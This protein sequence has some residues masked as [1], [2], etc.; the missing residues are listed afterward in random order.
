MRDIFRDINSP[1][2]TWKRAVL[3]IG[4]TC[5]GLYLLFMAAY[6]ATSVPSF[7]GACH[8]VKPY[9]ASWKE[10]PHK[11]VPCLYC[12][13]YRGFLGK[14]H[15]KARGLNYTYQQW[16]GQYT[17]ITKA[18][19]AEQNCIA[20][21]LGDYWNYPEAPRMGKDQY[22]YIKQNRSCLEC[23]RETGHKVNLFSDEKFKK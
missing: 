7:C 19:I 17:I 1:T 11:D 13:E 3:L 16:T 2:K 12:H 8:E 20:C 21:H 4:A 6:Y 9:Y 14:V 15:S 22:A 5:I 10:S 23:H 18:W